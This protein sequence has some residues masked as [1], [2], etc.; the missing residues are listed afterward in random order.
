MLGDVRGTTCL[1]AENATHG[2]MCQQ[3]GG[4]GLRALKTAEPGPFKL[5][6]R[7]DFQLP[8]RTRMPGCRTRVDGRQ[9][10]RYLLFTSINSSGN[11]QSGSMDDVL[12]AVFRRALQGVLH[13]NVHPARQ[14]KGLGTEP[15]ASQASGDWHAEPGE[16]KHRAKLYA[17]VLKQW[18]VKCA[19]AFLPNERW[20]LD[21]W[22]L[23][24]H[25]DGGESKP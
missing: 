22:A 10:G 24:S 16:M 19:T 14:A 23:Q 18:D 2:C 11:H 17:D 6:Y 7:A 1:F 8:D 3:Q 4:R 25:N 21:R 12:V 9:L 5:T 20:E 13:S 15:T